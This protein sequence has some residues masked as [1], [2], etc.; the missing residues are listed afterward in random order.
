MGSVQ[1]VDPQEAQDE[2]GREDVE[3]SLMLHNNTSTPLSEKEKELRIGRMTREFPDMIEYDPKTDMIFVKLM[4]RYS[5]LD[6]LKTASARIEGIHADFVKYGATTPERWWG[7]LMNI[8][9]VSI[10]AAWIEFNETH[11]VAKEKAEKDG[12]KNG[13][14]RNFS[15]IEK[16]FKTLYDLQKKYASPTPIVSIEKMQQLQEVLSRAGMEL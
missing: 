15:A 6:F 9:K 14:H 1:S 16:S 4:W 8:N 10:D 12:K 13:G 7:E 3:I 2:L 11:L 5:T